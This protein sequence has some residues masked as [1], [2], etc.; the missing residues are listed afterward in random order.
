MLIREYRNYFI[1]SLEDVYDKIESEEIFYL[2]LEH[3][4][5]LKK[6]DLALNPQVI[7]LE[8]QQVIFSDYLNRLLYHE[9]VQYIIGKTNFY[10]L[11]FKVNHNVLIPRPETEELVDWI[12]SENK[13]KEISILDIGT[14]SGAI[15][16]SL[17]KYLP[18]AKIYALDVSIEAIETA[19]ENA[20]HNGVNIQ[21][22]RQDILKTNELPF[23]FDVIV[24]N[25]P[26]IRELEKKEIKPNVLDHEPHLA[27]FVTDNNPLVFYDKI[28]QLS[29]N[30][31]NRNGKLYFEINQYLSEDMIELFNQNEAK[32]IILKKDIYNNDRMMS[33]TF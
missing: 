29:K 4:T 27:L 31:L 30:F 7:F 6:V 32:N 22:I 5:Q 26:Y 13:G 12:I 18:Q 2:L 19:K 10:G 8:N 17:A 24:S 3:L 11:D 16:V 15:A 1:T 14:G 28:I 33:S 25:P 20:T 23:N 21:F 9:P